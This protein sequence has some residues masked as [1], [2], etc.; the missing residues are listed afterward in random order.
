MRRR[1]AMDVIALPTYREGFPNVALEAAAMALPIVATSVPGC[2]DAVEDGAT[3]IL[4]PARDA[5]A[6][7]RALDRY[8][9]DPTLRATHGE[10]ARRRAVSQFRSE[11]IWEGVAQEYDDLLARSTNV[12]ASAPPGA[13]LR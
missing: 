2:V 9:T 8:L 12:P 10:A 6:L 5:E 7:A 4:V 3:G 13:S 1:S 11:A